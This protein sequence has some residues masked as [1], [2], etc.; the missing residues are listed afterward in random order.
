MRPENVPGCPTAFWAIFEF[1]Q[2]EQGAGSSSTALF[3]KNSDPALPF[4]FNRI[5]GIFPAF[6]TFA[7]HQ[8]VGVAVI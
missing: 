5:A 1:L 8:G 2:F 6:Y 7:Q 3:A 4:L